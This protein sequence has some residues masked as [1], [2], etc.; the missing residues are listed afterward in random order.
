MSLPAAPPA[1]SGRSSPRMAARPGPPGTTSAGYFLPA[2]DLPPAHG[3][4]DVST[5]L[6]K[7]PPA[8]CIIEQ[9]P[10]RGPAGKTLAGSS[11]RHQQ[12]PQRRVVTEWTSLSAAPTA[13]SGGSPPLLALPA[14][15]ELG[16]RSEAYSLRHGACC[17]KIR[18]P[19]PR[20]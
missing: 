2:Q 14:I 10:A 17:I 6:Y 15:G 12:Q 7:A 5:S 13:P 1:S 9:I 4:Q 3:A 19:P 20:A 8:P 18:S 16:L 11:R